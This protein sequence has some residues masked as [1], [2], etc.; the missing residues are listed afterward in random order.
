MN[1]KTRPERP[2]VFAI[3]FLLYLVLSFHHAMWTTHMGM[4]ICVISTV[5]SNI[6]KNRICQIIF[7]S[8]SCYWLLVGAFELK[9]SLQTGSAFAADISAHSLYCDIGLLT[10]LLGALA[11]ENYQKRK[12]LN[13]TPKI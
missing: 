1:P 8:S 10:V 12:S 5:V 13:E 4:A 6:T 2:E 11:W 7:A 3:G 9:R